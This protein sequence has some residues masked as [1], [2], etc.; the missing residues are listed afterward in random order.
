MSGRR[1][2]ISDR[3]LTL[4][5]ANFV[6]ESSDAARSPEEGCARAACREGA[7]ACIRARSSCSRR[8]DGTRDRAPVDL[9]VGAQ[10][11]GASA[12]GA[13][14]VEVCL[15][16]VWKK[17]RK[18]PPSRLD[19]FNPRPLVA[20]LEGCQTV[21]GSAPSTTAANPG[22]MATARHSKE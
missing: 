14:G 16:G 3:V 20:F 19:P 17:L 22:N 5:I 18:S 15:A 12:G 6:L 11:Q 9:G 10:V 8:F 21:C 13:G 7:E 2:P 1:S 4:V